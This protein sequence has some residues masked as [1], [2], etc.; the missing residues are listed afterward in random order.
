MSIDVTTSAENVPATLRALKRHCGL[1]DKEIA[2]TAGMK[3]STLNNRQSGLQ[4]ATA[5]ELQRLA[6]D[7]YDVPIFVLFFPPDE[8]VRWVIDHPSD[9]RKR[10]KSCSPIAA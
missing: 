3:R 9:L 6:K 5:D 2:E 4:P 10:Q 1:T 8:A 7:V